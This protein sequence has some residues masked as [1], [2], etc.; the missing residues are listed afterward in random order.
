[1][2]NLLITINQSVRVTT[3]PIGILSGTSRYMVRILEVH[4][5][6][7]RNQHIVVLIRIMSRNWF[8]GS[9][10]NNYENENICLF[11]QNSKLVNS[12]PNSV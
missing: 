4:R 3:K 6:S 7:Q 10:K 8:A 9:E 12:E 5:S 2:E 1:V 11:D